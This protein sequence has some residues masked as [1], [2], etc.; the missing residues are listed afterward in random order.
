MAIYRLGNLVPVCHES[1]FVADTAAVIGNVSLA[2]NTSVWFGATLRGDTEPISVGEGSNIQDGAVLHTEAGRALTI[3][4]SV[5]VGHQVVLHGCTIGHGSLIGIQAIVLDGAVIGRECLVAA[6]SVVT[7]DKVF[8]D[9]SLI[10]GSPARAVRRLSDDEVKR[11]HTNITFY[12]TS[13]RA[14]YR[15]QLMRMD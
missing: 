7:A 6:G 2:T 10:L 5:T 15:S 11:L 14:L 9:R 3:A 4:A 13:R 8:P 1:S 12:A